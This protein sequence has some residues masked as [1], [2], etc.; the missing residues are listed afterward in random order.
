[1]AYTS[2]MKFFNR[3][4]ENPNQAVSS[5]PIVDVSEYEKRIYALEQENK[6]LSNQMR[7][8]KEILMQLGQFNGS[9]VATQKGFEALSVDLQEKSVVAHESQIKSADSAM[10]VQSVSNHL[11]NLMKASEEASISLSSLNNDA[12]KIQGTINLIRDIAKQTDLLAL[13]AAIEAARAGEMGRGFAVVADEVRKLSERTA[14]AT[15][16]IN[17]I[18]TKMLTQVDK[19]TDAMGYLA[20][21]T[22]EVVSEGHDAYAYMQDLT[23]LST[24]LEKGLQQSAVRGFAELVKV[25]HLLY[26][27]RVYQVIFGLSQETKTAFADHTMCRLGKW[28]KGDGRHHH[29]REAA[30]QKLD[31][32][33]RL[34]HENAHRALEAHA[35]GRCE[36]MV[37]A[38]H[39][40]ERASQEVLHYLDQLTRA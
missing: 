34:V 3:K 11:E 35:L 23:T 6:Q 24:D 16:E 9:L 33:H 5:A 32:P 30:F 40:M 20:C 28:Y 4:K 15:D 19:T 17:T 27:F 10:A 31:N 2:V 38:V 21:Q 29:G 14:K 36:D 39:E 37:K 8:Q 25:D 1:M 7:C 13:N 12:D 18:M 26:K 22:S